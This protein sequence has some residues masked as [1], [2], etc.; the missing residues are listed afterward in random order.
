VDVSEEDTSSII[1]NERNKNT[2][3]VTDCH[4]SLLTKW[5]K[6]NNDYRKP[7]DIP[8]SKSN[9]CL[10]KLFISIREKGDSD[11]H[12]VSRQYEPE[13]LSAIHSSIQ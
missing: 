8:A 13:T 12:D 1:V 10:A 4:I 2:K 6:S 9:V 11:L 3:R 5:L 7:E